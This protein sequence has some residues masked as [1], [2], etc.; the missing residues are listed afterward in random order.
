MIVIGKLHRVAKVSRKVILCVVA[1]V[2][3]ANGLRLLAFARVYFE[4]C[5]HSGASKAVVFPDKWAVF[6]LFLS[7]TLYFNTDIVSDSTPNLVLLSTFIDA[8]LYARTLLAYYCVL[9]ALHANFDTAVEEEK[10]ERSSADIDLITAICPSMAMAMIG[11]S[12]C[13]C[14]YTELWLLVPL[15]FISTVFIFFIPECAVAFVKGENVG[16]KSIFD[17]VIALLVSSALYMTVVVIHLDWDALA[18][19]KKKAMLR[20]KE[21]RTDHELVA[22][23]EKYREDP[24]QPSHWD[25]LLAFIAPMIVIGRLHNLAGVSKRLVVNVVAAV[26]AVGVLRLVALTKIFLDIC[27][28]IPKE[29]FTAELE[30][31]EFYRQ[32]GARFGRVSIIFMFSSA[33]VLKAGSKNQAFFLIGLIYDLVMY[34]RILFAY[35]CVWKAYEVGVNLESSTDLIKPSVATPIAILWPP[36]AMAMSGT[37]RA[38]CAFFEYHAS[39]ASFLISKCIFLDVPYILAVWSKGGQLSLG[40]MEIFV[41]SFLFGICLY[42]NVF[43][44]SMGLIM[45]LNAQK[46]RSDTVTL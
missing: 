16:R 38:V 32:V 19:I 37:Y 21:T 44:R 14:I 17:N 25:W 13:D 36:L 11:I 45:L 40:I 15:A 2:F 3:L 33:A 43:S 41:V 10:T 5:F 34:T 26:C 20:A 7:S 12:R 4:M 9:R 35:Y 8:I 29:I 24:V 27:F 1:A 30:V 39:V 42:L 18:I 23:I 46:S 28:E 22:I 6:R 31:Q